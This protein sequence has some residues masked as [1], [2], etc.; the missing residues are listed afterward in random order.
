MAIR[1]LGLLV[2]IVVCAGCVDHYRADEGSPMAPDPRF[3]LSMEQRTSLRSDVDPH[4]L[5]SLLDRVPAENRARV[6]SMY[7][8]GSRDHVLKFE[9]PE[10]QAL[11]ERAIGVQ[12][13]PSATSGL[14]EVQA[15]IPVQVAIVPDVPETSAGAVIL[16]TPNQGDVVLLPQAHASALQLYVA[17]RALW[18]AR[19][20]APTLGRSSRM[21]VRIAP[22]FAGPSAEQVEARAEAEFGPTLR[23][24][25]DAS[26]RMLNGVGVVRFT[27]FRSDP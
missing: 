12:R 27:E 23:A 5:E 24:A 20:Q 3:R 17:M 22:R 4:A 19:Q 9:D 25:H 16:R 26:P 11:H 15:R 10:L 6:L 13:G 7:V 14:A 2:V 21:V 18:T 8:A 1:R